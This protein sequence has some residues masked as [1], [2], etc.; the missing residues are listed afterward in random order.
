MRHYKKDYDVAEANN[1]LKL[2]PENAKVSAQSPFVP[3]LAFR[4]YIYQFPAI[5]DA[6]YIV[7]STEEYSYPLSKQS[8]A[9]QTALLSSSEEWGKVYDKNEMII[10]KRR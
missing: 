1:A 3:H 5:N 9:V 7:L 4:D 6:E 8:F 10:L 2:I